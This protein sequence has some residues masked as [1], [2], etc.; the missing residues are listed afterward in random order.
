MYVQTHTHT[1]TF[2]VVTSQTVRSKSYSAKSEQC[3][4][5]QLCVY[6]QRIPVENQN[7]AHWN[8]ISFSITALLPCY[9]PVVFF[10]HFCLIALSFLQRNFRFTF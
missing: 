10:R 8:M 1:P 4:H 2:A 5:G 9:R 3:K 6:R 7:L